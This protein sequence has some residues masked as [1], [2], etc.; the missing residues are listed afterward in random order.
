MPGIETAA[1]GADGDEERILRVPESL[2]RLLLEPGEGTGDLVLETVREAARPHELD[3]G[4]RR[5]GEARRD[6]DSERGHLGE[7]GSLAAQKLTADAGRVRRSCRRTA[8]SRSA[9]S[10]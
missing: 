7:A 9:D 1:P 2:A 5:D 3:A 10:T 8:P 6:R 4:L